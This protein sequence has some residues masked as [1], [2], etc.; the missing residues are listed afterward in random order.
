MKQ[1]PLYYMLGE[2]DNTYWVEANGQRVHIRL[3]GD[4]DP[5]DHVIEVT[6]REQCFAPKV[7]FY[8]T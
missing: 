5:R 4:A 3:P 1:V 2:S 8:L 6:N 7:P